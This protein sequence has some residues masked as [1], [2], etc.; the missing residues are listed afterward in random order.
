MPTIYL[1]GRSVGQFDWA[2]VRTPHESWIDLHVS[3]C[4]V[5]DRIIVDAP[6]IGYSGGQNSGPG[7]IYPSGASRPVAAEVAASVPALAS[8]FAEAVA[9]LPTSRKASAA[10][11]RR[12]LQ[13]ILKGAGKAKKRDLAD[14][15]DEVMPALPPQIAENIDA[16]RHVG[17]F[18]AHPMKSTNTGEIVDVE[19]GEAE[20]LLDV[21][22]DLFEF[23]FVAPARAAARRDA[24]NQKLA[25]L[26][27]P[28]LKKPAP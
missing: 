21:I 7:V 15:I 10:L 2:R 14:Q 18:A 22:E 16:V 8:D 26:G 20:W 23:Y 17:N 5:C 13:G 6:T 3:N 25:D 24:L 1:G 28:A 9:V 19:D 4:P 11:S 27:K 12:C